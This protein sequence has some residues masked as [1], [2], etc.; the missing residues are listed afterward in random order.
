MAAFLT[1]LIVVIAIIVPFVV[2]GFFVFIEARDL[3]IYF[4]VMPV[5]LFYKTAFFALKISSAHT[6]QMYS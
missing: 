4:Q 1:T 2:V 6:H 3:Y 5:L